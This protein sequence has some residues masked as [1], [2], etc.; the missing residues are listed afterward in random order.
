MLLEKHG[1][2]PS[3]VH[4]RKRK[5]QRTPRRPPKESS[6]EDAIAISQDSDYLIH[7]N[8]ATLILVMPKKRK[9]STEDEV[10]RCDVV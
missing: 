1:Q 5:R 10:V 8:V 6:Q 7:K 2:S 3:L 9:E 4:T